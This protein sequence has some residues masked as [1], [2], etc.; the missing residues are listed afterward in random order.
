MHPVDWVSRGGD[1]CLQA[2]QLL[3][4]TITFAVGGGHSFAGVCGLENVAVGLSRRQ[5]LLL[6]VAPHSPSLA[7][8]LTSAGYCRPGSYCAVV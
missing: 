3:L 6:C 1:Q 7:C 2:S 8:Y 5:M 4:P